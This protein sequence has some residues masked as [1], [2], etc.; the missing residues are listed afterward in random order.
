MPKTAPLPEDT[1]EPA[2]S[3][4]PSASVHP[5][6]NFHHVIFAHLTSC[7]AVGP[8]SARSD[9]SCLKYLVVCEQVKSI[10]AVFRSQSCSR[11]SVPPLIQFGRPASAQS[12]V[13]TSSVGGAKIFRWESKHF[14]RGNSQNPTIP[15]KTLGYLNWLDSTIVKWRHNSLNYLRSI[16]YPF[17]KP[18]IQQLCVIF[19]F[20]T[21]VLMACLEGNHRP[22]GTISADLADCSS[23]RLRRFAESSSTQMGYLLNRGQE[24]RS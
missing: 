5:P 7:R 11:C 9:S 3:G 1:V 12:R 22:I 2:G 14:L 19:H 15:R 4:R 21:I 10:I 18:Q 6:P 13:C 20:L 17:H 24:T 8:G 16:Q 23:S